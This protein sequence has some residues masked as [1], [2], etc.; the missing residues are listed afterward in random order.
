MQG[1][2]ESLE[3]WDD[4]VKDRYDPNRTQ[5]GF[6]QFTPEAPPVVR[7]FY[8]L[9]HAHQTRDFVLQK[10]RQYLSLDRRPMGIWEAIEYL[11]TLVDD[12]D[13]DTG[14]LADRTLPAN[15]GSHP[16]RRASALVHPDWIDPRSG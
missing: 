9:N 10:K 12:S 8:R 15:R 16:G 11:N 6:R 5:D 4:F 14:P 7:Q 1:P 2:L 3:Q 13:P